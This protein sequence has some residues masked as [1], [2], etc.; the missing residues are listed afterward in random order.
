M[1]AVAAILEV[2]AYY[3]PGVDNLLDTIATPAALIAG[4][5]V[6]AAVLTDMPPMLKWTTAIIAG[7]GIAG[8]TQGATAA[9]RAKSTVLTAGF[10]TRR[11]RHRRWRLRTAVD[12]R[13]RS[14]LHRPSPR[15]TAVG[16]SSP[17]RKLTRAR[18]KPTPPAET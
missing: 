10:A 11:L 18:A 4:T 16:R 9:V 12:H 17:Y 1:L 6:S 3:V 13:A 7:G 14:T 2:I 15:H 8:V 5:I